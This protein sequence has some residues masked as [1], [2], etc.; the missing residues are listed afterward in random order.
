MDQTDVN[1]FVVS[2]IVDDDLSITS[3]LTE[4]YNSRPRKRGNQKRHSS[5]LIMSWSRLHLQK[6]NE[7]ILVLARRK[8][9]MCRTRAMFKEYVML[10]DGRSA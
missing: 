3:Y 4:E 5:L 1:A 7:R 6:L 10:H 2:H 9:W 8:M